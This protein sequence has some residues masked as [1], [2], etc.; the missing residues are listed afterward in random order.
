M[1]NDDFLATEPRKLVTFAMIVMV[2][3]S[4]SEINMNHNDTESKLQKMKRNQ[5]FCIHL[6]PFPD[7]KRRQRGWV[8][9][10]NLKD[11]CER[12][13]NDASTFWSLNASSFVPQKTIIIIKIPSWFLP[14]Y[15]LQSLLDCIGHCGK[16]VAASVDKL[17]TANNSQHLWRHHMPPAFQNAN[18]IIVS[19][20][21]RVYSLLVLLFQQNKRQ[22]LIWLNM[23]FTYPRINN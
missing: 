8:L 14:R 6:Y 1:N 17:L 9:C 16:M 12:D 18:P 15:F 7:S 21:Y 3:I 4:S 2:T 23:E 20:H 13:W 19:L 11:S 22:S 5:D 10:D